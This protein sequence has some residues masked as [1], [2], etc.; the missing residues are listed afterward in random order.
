MRIALI[1]LGDIAQKA[2]L[3]LLAAN[4]D[5]TP[6]LCTRNAAILTSLSRQ[7]RITETYTD[8]EALIKSAPAGAMVHSS[9][10]S[11]PAIVAKLLNAGIAVFVDKP[12]SYHA[13]ESERLLALAATKQLPLFVGFNRR[14]APLIRSIDSHPATQI[15]LQKNRARQPADARVF[16]FDD[17]IHVLDTLRFLGGGETA[18]LQVEAFY[19][20]TLL[21]AI[22]VHWQW[23]QTLLAGSMNRISGV[24]EEILEFFGCEQKWQI[25]NLSG[26]WHY[27]D[28]H[29]VEL[30]F[31]DWEHT[32]HKRGFMDMI[33]AFLQQV[34]AGTSP[35]DQYSDILATHRLCERVLAQAIG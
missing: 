28:N 35:A 18:D 1:G 24:T 14:Y 15:R 3:P 26:G 5:I 7:Y 9:T 2:Y 25:K 32:L 23:Q 16:I 22:Q 13:D 31:S 11:H 27:R 21:A 12:L 8:L 34:E 29:K 4:A 33:E 20:Q 6:V 10:D 17:F 19:Q 30:G